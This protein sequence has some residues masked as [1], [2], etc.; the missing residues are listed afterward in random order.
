MK[1]SYF[2]FVSVL[3]TAG[4]GRA[5]VWSV[6]VTLSASVTIEVEFDIQRT[7]HRDI[8]L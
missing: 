3:F 2:Y 4:R 7:V 8:F 1:N 6:T 5:V